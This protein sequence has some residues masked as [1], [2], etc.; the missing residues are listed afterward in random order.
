MATFR[1]GRN[2]AAVAF[3]GETGKPAR[4]TRTVSFGIDI[5][6]ASLRVR[7]ADSLLHARIDARHSFILHRDS[8]RLATGLMPDERVNQLGFNAECAGCNKRHQVHQWLTPSTTMCKL[9][10]DWLA[11]LCSANGKLVL[12]TS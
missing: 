6:C 9:D 11:L 7:L 10:D 1:H 8:P 4:P 2:I 3:N 5:A 12:L